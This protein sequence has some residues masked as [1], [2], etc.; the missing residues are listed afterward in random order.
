VSLSR[1]HREAAYIYY[2]DDEKRLEFYAG[3]ADTKHL[4]LSAPNQLSVEDVREV[5]PNLA[6]GLAKL[7]FQ[8]YTI[9]RQGE[10]QI[11]ASG[12]PTGDRDSCS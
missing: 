10:N 5:V 2:R 1:V 11:I 7:G 8:H 12:P 3:P 4:Y 9:R 6:K